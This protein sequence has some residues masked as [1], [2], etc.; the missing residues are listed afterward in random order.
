MVVGL[1]FARE[2]LIKNLI[3]RMFSFE[4]QQRAL[5][6]LI[7]DERTE[8]EHGAWDPEFDGPSPDA[9]SRHF[10]TRG[11]KA[12]LGLERWYRHR[13]F[14]R[15]RARVQTGPRSLATLTRILHS[16]STPLW[17]VL[18]TVP[19][20]VAE[21]AVDLCIERFLARG[22]IRP[23]DPRQGQEADPY[24]LVLDDWFEIVPA[25]PPGGKV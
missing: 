13:R 17:R 19:D 14:G 2:E 6:H 25:S 15:P 16:L 12:E 24:A 7:S 20:D 1:L 22:K 11:L 23:I 8:Y 18:V 5:S 21:N 9:F 10:L 3:R 4:V